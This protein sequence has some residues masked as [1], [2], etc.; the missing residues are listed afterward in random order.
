MG[1][2]PLNSLFSSTSTFF[3]HCG[4]IGAF[5]NEPAQIAVRNILSHFDSFPECY[6]NIEINCY[7]H[8]ISFL[9][10]I[11]DV[12]LDNPRLADEV[13]INIGMTNPS[14]FHSSPEVLKYMNENYS[15]FKNHSAHL[16]SI[17]LIAALVGVDP[18]AL[19]AAAPDQGLKLSVHNSF[20]RTVSPVLESLDLLGIPDNPHE[21]LYVSVHDCTDFLKTV[22]EVENLNK[23][24]WGSE[25]SVQSAL[26]AP[27]VIFQLIH[28]KNY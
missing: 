12:F 24:I 11:C 10:I 5:R 17:G 14:Q 22:G 1:L 15:D 19:S 9:K 4:Q 2:S 18:E 6:K 20:L 28:L 27:S 3:Q 16:L 26:L 25:S 23:A 7:G 8:K 21:I 13:L